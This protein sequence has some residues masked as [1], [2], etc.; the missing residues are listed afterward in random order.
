MLFAFFVVKK[1]GPDRKELR[2][3]E[4]QPKG[5]LSRGEAETQRKK[6]LRRARKLSTFAVQRRQKRTTPVQEI[7]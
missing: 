7:L 4:P 1:T 2:V 6:N 5:E 3:A